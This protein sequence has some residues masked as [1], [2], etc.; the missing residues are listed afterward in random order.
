MKDIKIKVGACQILTSKDIIQNTEKVTERIK[1]A[2]SKGI[3]ILSF[4]E[5][6]LFGYCCEDEYWKYAQLKSFE[7]A[8]NIISSTCKSC[9]IAVIVGSAHKENG[10]W[11]NSLAIFDKDGKLKYRYGKTFLAGERWCIN[12]KGKLPIVNLAGIDCCFLICHDIRYPELVRL[13]AIAGAQICFFCSCES[14]LIAEHKLSAYRSMPISRATENGIYLVMANTP[15]D[16]DDIKSSCSSH[17]NSKIIHPDGN[18]IVESGFFTQEIIS[19]EIDLSKADRWVAK[20]A[21]LEDTILHDWLQKG[22]DCVIN[23]G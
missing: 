20:R 5:G 14:G 7:N 9:N 17:G 18:V 22:L 23:V 4:P 15:A 6:T 2:Y 10:N 13:P 11:L 3:E 12:N 1:E 19:A 8:E 16:S 21:F